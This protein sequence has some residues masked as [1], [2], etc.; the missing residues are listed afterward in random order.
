ME[1]FYIIGKHQVTNEQFARFMSESGYRA[2]G[3]WRDH[4]GIGREK[5]PVVC[6]TCDDALAY[7]RWAG[8]NLPNDA[9]WEKAARGGDPPSRRIPERHARKAQRAGCRLRGQR[10]TAVVPLDSR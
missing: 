9:Q 2:Q 3:S 5:H 10:T 7:C 1:D 8:L 4:A 6:V